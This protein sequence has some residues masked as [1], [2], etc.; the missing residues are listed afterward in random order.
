MDRESTARGVGASQKA[1]I[2]PSDAVLIGLV[3]AGDPDA[4]DSLYRRHAARALRRAHYLAHTW[5]G[6][7]DLRAEA[8]TRVLSAIRHGSGPT[9]AMLPYLGTVMRRIADD[10]QRGERQVYLAARTMDVVA[11][12]QQGDSVL[13]AQERSMAAVAFG[14][15]TVL[16][17]PFACRWWRACFNEGVVNWRVAGTIW[18]RRVCRHLAYGRVRGRVPT[19]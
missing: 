8:F 1:D 19:S 9:T 16:N 15:G 18:Q 17:T 6:A 7:E 14:V 13:A 11:S 4:F 12:A 5:A 2:H 3:R 10:W